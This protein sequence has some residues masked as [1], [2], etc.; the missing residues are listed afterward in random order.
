MPR[1][2]LSPEEREA[3]RK[4][5]ARH[6]FSDAAYKHYDPKAEGYGS[7]DE[8]INAA[9]ALAGGIPAFAR[10][11]GTA[12]SPDLTALF[13]EKMPDSVEALKRAFRNA[14]MVAHPD[15]GGTNEQARDVM[16]AYKRLLKVF[17]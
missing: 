11:T 17:T 9:E 14:M 15:H 16:A 12:A 13:L 6:S 1:V 2:T 8:W 10:V 5:R 3:R 7:A 4:E